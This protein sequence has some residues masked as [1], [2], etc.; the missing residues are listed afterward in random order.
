[1]TEI[2]EFTNKETIKAIQINCL[3]DLIFAIKR[4]KEKFKIETI[5]ECILF[6][7]D[8]IKY[9]FIIAEHDSVSFS[10]DFGDYFCLSENSPFLKRRP[11]EY[12][13]NKW[14]EVEEK[15]EKIVTPTLR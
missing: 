9:T 4:W 8:L 5:E 10:F 15:F 1:M 2:K 3:E 7:K 11:K 6:N 13:D 14:S 12:V